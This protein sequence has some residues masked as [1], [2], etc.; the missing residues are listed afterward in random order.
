M[1]FYKSVYSGE[2]CPIRIQDIHRRFVS[3]VLVE[4]ADPKSVLLAEHPDEHADMP[5]LT[6]E[7]KVED[8]IR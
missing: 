2:S 1:A 3:D 7:R 5:A 6:R 4:E 8:V